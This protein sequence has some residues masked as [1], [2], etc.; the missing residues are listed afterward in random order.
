MHKVSSKL[1]QDS[2]CSKNKALCVH[3]LKYDYVQTYDDT[4]VPLV[5][6]KKVRAISDNKET[7]NNTH[8][9]CGLWQRLVMYPVSVKMA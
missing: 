6:C 5:C 1:D 2:V 4:L 8:M 7:E 3:C 9:Q